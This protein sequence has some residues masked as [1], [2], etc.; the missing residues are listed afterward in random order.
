MKPIEKL[1]TLLAAKA[2]EHEWLGH[3]MRGGSHGSFTSFLTHINRFRITIVAHSYESE[4]DIS[5]RVLRRRAVPKGVTTWIEL[6][7]QDDFARFGRRCI[8]DGQIIL[9]E[10]ELYAQASSL[11]KAVTANS[12]MFSQHSDDR[13]SV[14]QSILAVCDALA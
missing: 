6:S 8:L 1:I 13:L 7:V 14:N 9:P 3:S 4:R 11:L 10:D 12:K 5:T 2:Q